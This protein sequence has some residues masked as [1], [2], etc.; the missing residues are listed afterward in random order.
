MTAYLVYPAGSA[1]AS[2]RI[3]ESL[4]EIVGE[5]R[6]AQ[7]LSEIAPKAGE[8]AIVFVLGSGQANGRIDEIV[9]FS[10][11]DRQGAYCVYVASELDALE[12]KRLL[13]TGNA[14]WV[15]M[16]QAESELPDVVSRW[17]M[18][19]NAETAGDAGGSTVISFLPSG[20]GVGNTTLVVETAM[21][22]AR[23]QGKHARVCVVD[24]N[25]QDGNVCDLLNID[26]RL[27][28]VEL[29][30]NPDRLDDHML[31][32][33]TSKHRSGF[34]VLAS[35]K[36]FL[37][38]AS[39]NP[40]AVYAIFNALNFR[41]DYVLVDFPHVWL[42][43]TDNLLRNSDYIVVSGIY[44]VPSAMR[45]AATKRQLTSIG[46]PKTAVSVV[47]NQY[48]SSLFS[49]GFG[50]S[51]FEEAIG[52]GEVFYVSR[53]DSFV[54]ESA[55][56]GEPMMSIKARRRI[57]KDIAKVARQAAASRSRKQ[58]AAAR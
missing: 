34:D 31:E 1:K 5:V 36:L 15:P 58:G 24:T 23:H 57:C 38:Y 29:S 13:K 18:R 47:V 40:D 3:A 35:G 20:G 45:I 17:L 28:I 14:E 53:D 25:F 4:R 50:T 32:I 48:V 10:D 49:R 55:N 7:S 37:D 44:T 33:F 21:W 52:E 27:D 8:R 6:E 12:Y 30:S 56:L 19:I 2:E 43:W 42:P 16:Q 11:R 54:A 9:E 41:Y 46:I 51:E 39:V 22:L 26:P